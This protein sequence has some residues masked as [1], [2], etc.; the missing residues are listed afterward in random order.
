MFGIIAAVP[1]PFDQNNKPNLD[2]FLSHCSWALENGC[3][4]LNIL[5][6]T[7][8][9][10]SIDLKTRKLIMKHA[11][12][13]LDVSKL[14]VGTGTPS[15]RETIQLTEFADSLGYNISLILPPY[16]YKP[17]SEG[18]LI[19]WF[20]TIA[21]NLKGKNI[22]IFFYNFPQMTGFHIPI[23]VIKHLISHWPEKFL[24]IK[25][26]SGD[27]TY[28]KEIA[29]LGKGFKVFPSSESFLGEAQKSNFAG[30]IS[31]TANQTSAICAEIWKTRQE[32]NYILVEKIK[33]IRNMISKESLIPSIKYLVGKRTEKKDWERL[34]PPLIA[35][36]EKRKEELDI[37]FHTQ[38]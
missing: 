3:N 25:D 38:I 34:M 9:A 7:G 6:S 18:G 19:S 26:S 4:G 36:P 37:F 35:L 33:K 30:C 23:A 1:T 20:E 11:S 16:Y 21:R 10:N 2:L 31:A 14:M 15:L 29:T 22:K 12:E 5:G 27:L 8:E 24:G 32:T 28:C 13:N 17:V